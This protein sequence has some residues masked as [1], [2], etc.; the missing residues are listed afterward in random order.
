MKNNSDLGFKKN[1]II[2]LI[3]D[4]NGSNTEGIGHIGNYSFFVKDTIKGEKIRAVVTKLNKNYGFAKCIEIISPSKYRIEPKCEYY[5]RC[6]GCNLQHMS[7]EGQIEYKKNKIL[8]TL[9]KIAGINLDNIDIILSENEFRYRNKAQY[10]VGYDKDGMIKAGFYAS[11][12]HNI[13][14][15]RDCILEPEINSKII[16]AVLQFCDRN[17]L[18]AYNEILNEGDIRHIMIRHTDNFEI[19]VCLIINTKKN[20]EQFFWKE[21]FDKINE[22]IKIYNKNNSLNYR[23]LSFNLNFNNKKTNVIM[24]EKTENIIGNPYILDSMNGINYAISV[25]SFYQVNAKQA[26]KLYEIAAR[27]ADINSDDVVFDM[28]CGTGTIGLYLAKYAKCVFGVEIVKEAIEMANYNKKINKTDNIEFMC[29]SADIVLNKLYNDGIMPNIIVVD[30]PRKGLSTDMIDNILRSAPQK[31]VYISCD[32]ATLARDLKILLNDGVYKLKEFVGVDQFCQTGH[33]ETVALLSKLDV[34]KHIDVEI[35][36]DELDF[37]SAES[38]GIYEQ[39]LVGG[40]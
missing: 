30:P 24:G 4:D 10:P 8:N 5:K 14:P 13:V 21:C 27:M 37:T 23:F 29:G 32:I 9:R 33:V 26:A 16:E 40:D 6:G 20:K 35:K 18:T 31:I 36:L 28:Y 2:E 17:N 3:I 11:R 25:N 1:D 15:I 38:K 19:M 22:E 12:S 34:D 39:I 7:Y